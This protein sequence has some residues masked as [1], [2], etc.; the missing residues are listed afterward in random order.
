MRQEFFQ[1][2]VTETGDIEF[3]PYKGF[4]QKAIVLA[5]EIEAFVSAIIVF[6]GFRDFGE[7][8]DSPAGIIKSGNKFKITVVR[9]PQ[10]GG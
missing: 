6:H 10:L 7:I 8:F 3:S 1:G 4:K 2:F 9:C 5:E